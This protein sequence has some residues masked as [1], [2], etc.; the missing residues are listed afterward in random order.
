MRTQ[1]DNSL[2]NELEMSLSEADMNFQQI[3]TPLKIN[4]NG[5]P[6]IMISPDADQAKINLENVRVIFSLIF[7]LHEILRCFFV[8]NRES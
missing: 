4:E 2:F 5:L 3:S 1:S 7:R 8:H 6:N